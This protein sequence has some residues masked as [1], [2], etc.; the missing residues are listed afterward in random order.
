[1]VLQL[2]ADTRLVLK[3]LLVAYSTV[4][5]AHICKTLLKKRFA[6]PSFP[7]F[8]DTLK[9]R[10]EGSKIP[11]EDTKMVIL[12]RRDLKMGAGKIAA[13]CGHAVALAM[14]QSFDKN[15][16]VLYQWL[17]HSQAKVALKVDS[18]EQL[19]EYKEKAKKK[20]LI[21]S[22]ITDAG[23]TQIEPNTVTVLGIGPDITEKFEDV[24]GD[25]KL[26]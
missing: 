17:N 25:L 16:A 24:T 10:T 13:Q 21:T 1:M 19:E 23:R 9:A 15:P 5:I 20:G 14:V 11:K 6:K 7:S 12:V 8:R 26:L 4:L 2:S 18:L 3:S 22:K